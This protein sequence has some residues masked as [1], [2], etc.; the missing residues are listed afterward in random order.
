[1]T[2]AEYEALITDIPEYPEPGV[3]FKD[4]T[5]W[6]KD[7]DGFAAAVDDIAD[8]FRSMGITKVV[9]SEAR[10]FMIGAPVAYALHAGFVPARKPGKLPRETMSQTYELEYGHDTLEVHL[11]AF[12]KDDVVLIVD[13]LAATGGT[14]M[15]QI[16]LVQAS[17]AKLAG[18]AYMIEL[19]T[20]DPRTKIG[21]LTDCEMYSL[22]DVTEY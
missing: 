21:K 18:I 12:D 9:G 13:D 10:G 17:G 3:T 5:T 20:L 14:M 11:D 2:S 16:K 19:T 6:L 1:M 4:I 22:V 8:H 7:V 15:A